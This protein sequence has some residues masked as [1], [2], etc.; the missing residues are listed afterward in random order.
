[1]VLGGSW[2]AYAQADL[3]LNPVVAIVASLATGI[4]MVL[5]LFSESRRQRREL[6]HRLQEE[7]VTAA[8]A[9]GELDAARSIQ[10]GMLPPPERLVKLDPRLDIAGLVEPAKSIGGDFFDCVT[11]APGVHAF[12]VGDVSGKGVGA[13]LF[14]A[15][16]KALTKSVLLRGSSGLAEA[17]GQ[18]NTEVSRDN[19][20]DMF[21]TLLVA[22][23]DAETGRLTLCAAGHEYP[24]IVRADGSIEM[25][26]PEGGPPVGVA[27]GFPYGA[28]DMLLGEG[29]TLVIVSDGITE[30]KAPDEDYFEHPRLRMVLEGWRP[31]LGSGKIVTLLRDAVRIFEA[32][33]E[34][35]DDLTVLAVRR[36]G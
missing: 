31:E 1:L 16:S 2:L 5:L 12:I 21:V 9:Q 7:R 18:I 23:L 35:T 8:Q 33:Q 17:V 28:S 15:L 34:A 10:L 14:M 13:A 26:K 3:L 25:I 36:I 4:T 30:A 20:E 24:W 6:A 22:I 27:P 32:D 11:V 19:S 29:D